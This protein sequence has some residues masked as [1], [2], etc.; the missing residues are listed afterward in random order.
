MNEEGITYEGYNDWVVWVA[1][2][3]DVVEELTTTS[4]R[5]Q[6]ITNPDWETYRFYPTQAEAEVAAS[7][8]LKKNGSVH[9][10]KVQH[11]TR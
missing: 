11:I 5:T 4:G 7:D 10:V 1:W 6:Q 9:A 2:D 8:I 3:V